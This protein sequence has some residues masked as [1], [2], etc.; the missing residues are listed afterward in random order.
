[1][2]VDPRGRLGVDEKAS[3]SERGIALGRTTQVFAAPTTPLRP[4][5]EASCTDVDVRMTPETSTTPFATPPA[6][7]ATQP[8]RPVTTTTASFTFS[9]PAHQQASLGVS[10]RKTPGSLSRFGTPRKMV[11]LPRSKL[12]GTLD[13]HPS[14]LS[15]PASIKGDT[16]PATAARAAH[17]AIEA[18]PVQASEQPAPASTTS[19]A[20]DTTF[21]PAPSL[22]EP[23]PALSK[24]STARP[25][26][27][28][29]RVVSGTGPKV[30][31]LMGPPSLPTRSLR[32]STSTRTLAGRSDTAA[33]IQSSSASTCSAIVPTQSTL[34]RSSTL[35]ASTISS[36]AKTSLPPAVVPNVGSGAGM[37]AGK[38]APLGEIRRPGGPPAFG[39]SQE[40]KSAAVAARKPSYPSSLSVGRGQPG[41][42]ATGSSSSTAIR[43]GPTGRIGRPRDRTL[44]G[45]V[46]ASV[47]AAFRSEGPDIDTVDGGSP[48]DKAQKS[49]TRPA[50]GAGTPPKPSP[51]RVHSASSGRSDKL[52]MASPTRRVVSAPV[53][54]SPL[55]S[56]AA[57]APDNGDGK[58]RIHPLSMST[59]SATDRRE[60]LGLSMS[61]RRQGSGWNDTSKSFVGL[62]AALERLKRKDSMVGKGVRA[63]L[64]VGS[65]MS[66]LS[67]GSVDGASSAGEAGRAQR[68][69][70]GTEGA[71]VVSDRLAAVHRPRHSIAIGATQAVLPTASNSA[72]SISSTAVRAS[73]SGIPRTSTLM[74][75]LPVGSADADPLVR[76]KAAMAARCLKGVV[77][78]VDVWTADG[79]D[80]S[81][82]FQDMLRGMGARVC[83]LVHCRQCSQFMTV[84]R[85]HEV[86][87]D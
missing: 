76:A 66:A 30:T 43:A 61:E 1:M 18:V 35:Y 34:P 14:P 5:S 20:S 64:G 71:K 13:Q 49:P 57:D 58:A 28:I 23:V 86:K 36:A 17:V 2:D 48:D 15:K 72:S 7:V 27:P 52:S 51:D 47:L 65:G 10:S 78:F 44:S 22:E 79:T 60:S 8:T 25:T 24:A 19:T 3:E 37:A 74:A 21:S 29:K 73:A 53:R 16:Q 32:S 59:S 62:A 85:A 80:S 31:G 55:F 46:P 54:S 45:P 84:E 9:S 67:H 63:S 50:M 81:A 11:P 41:L 83:R 68:A 69:D 82:I 56:D 39:T 6:K 70:A 12:G 33:R 42:S 40:P 75:A 87:A 38:K 4:R 26:Q 77:A